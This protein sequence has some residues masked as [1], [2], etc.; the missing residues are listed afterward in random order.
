MALKLSIVGSGNVAWNL[1]HALDRAGHSIMQVIS[2]DVSHAEALAKRFGAFFGTDFSELYGDSDLIIFSISDDQY[3]GLMHSIK[4]NSDAV[5]CHTSGPVSM[6]VLSEAS[7]RYGVFY[8]LQSFN[9]DKLKEF[10]DVPILVE[11]VDAGVEKMLMQLADSISNHV[12]MVNSF[13]RKKYHLSAVFA[14]NFTNA[15]YISAERYL[16]QEG[17]DFD[18]LKPIIYET[19]LRISDRSPEE[20]QTG[21]AIRGDLKVLEK[22]IEMIK[23][24]ALKEVYEQLSKL[25][26]T[27][28]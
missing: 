25:I 18:V 16:N 19:A 21:P 6:E 20:V 1:A 8:P 27:L 10:W 11:G 28:R 4:L 15:M 22:H 13:D 23:D 26:M 12:R 5:I 17:L 3:A 2:R 7:T 24:P 9:K 14:N